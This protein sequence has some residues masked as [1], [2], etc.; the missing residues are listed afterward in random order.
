[1]SG[2]TYSQ[3]IKEE[4]DDY[5]YFPEP[6]IPPLYFEDEYI[7]SLREQIPELPEVLKK[8]YL[9]YGIAE[10]IAE[11]I[12]SSGFRRDY[13]AEF[14]QQVKDNETLQEVAKLLVGDLS[15]LVDSDDDD[16]E[17]VSRP[18]VAAVLKTIELRK[19]ST[20]TSNTQSA[21]LQKLIGGE[22]ETVEDIKVYIEE[23]DL[24]VESDSGAIKDIAAKIIAQDPQA[25]EKYDKNPNVAMYFVGQVMRETKGSADPKVT[26]EV[27]EEILNSM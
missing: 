5:R 26:K 6:D 4:A 3:R 13:M 20:I 21:I 15:A 9:G 22:L 8:R 14:E 19:N 24:A 25:K 23:N 18:A 16:A 2:K 17:P 1:M 27:V 12:V 7:E 11:D 10:N